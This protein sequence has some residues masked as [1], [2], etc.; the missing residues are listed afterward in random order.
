MSNTSIYRPAYDKSWALVIGINRYTTVLPLGNARQDA[1]A[2][3]DTLVANFG[4]P[5]AN[6]ITLFDEAATRV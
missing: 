6:V 1:E 3:A 4:F 5:T 2:F